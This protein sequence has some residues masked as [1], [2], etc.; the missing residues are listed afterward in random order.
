VISV[1]HETLNASEMCF[2]NFLLSIQMYIYIYH[3]NILQ[4]NWVFCLGWLIKLGGLFSIPCA[5]IVHFK[6]P[7]KWRD[8][9]FIY[10]A[11]YNLIFCSRIKDKNKFAYLKMNI[12]S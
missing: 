3:M 2:G 8:I 4:R 11:Q 7:F 9:E 5:F 1:L 10:V 12:F 6:S